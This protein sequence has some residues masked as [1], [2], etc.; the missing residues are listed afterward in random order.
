M[1]KNGR[2]QQA[3]KETREYLEIN[4]DRDVD[5]NDA[6]DYL[7]GDCGMD[8]NGFCSKAGSEECDFECPFSG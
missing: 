2:L 1:S 6:L 5:D 7:I 4:S 8:A 3:I